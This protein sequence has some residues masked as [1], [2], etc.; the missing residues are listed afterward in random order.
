MYLPNDNDKILYKRG[1]LARLQLMKIHQ[2]TTSSLGNV[3]EWFDFG[4][5]IFLAPIIGKQFFSTTDET[6]STMAAFTVFAAGF[7]CRPI[8]GILFGH[9]GDRYGRAKPLRYSIIITTAVTF[10][11]GILPACTTIGIF[12]PLLFTLLRLIQGI[13]IGGEYGGIMIYLAETAP[14]KKRGFITSFAATGANMGFLLATLGTLLLQSMLPE[15]AMNNWGWRIPFIFIGCLGCLISYYRLKLMETPAYQQVKENDAI[16]KIP[17]FTALRCVPKKLLQILGLSGASNVFYYAFFGYMPDYLQ[18]YAGLSSKTAF[19][20]CS[21]TLAA[22]LVLVPLMSIWGDRYGRKKLLIIHAILI[23]LFA[24]PC[25][26]WLNAQNFGLII[27]ALSIAT[28]LGSLGQGLQLAA[29]VENCPVDIRYSGISLAY[30]VGAATFGG[31]CPLIMLT[32][33][34][35]FNPIAPAYYLIATAAVG[36]LSVA[37]LP[38]NLQQNFLSTTGSKLEAE[39][40]DL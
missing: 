29:T 17:L 16:K 28:L 4:L 37:T 33:I 38:D 11:I 23:M 13:S 15:A 26:Y 6:T 35:I 30:N 8:G 39:Q 40:T 27:F 14:S 24:L 10:L 22:M 21:L 20:L 5:F 12:A 9:I 19:T 1:L 32:L 7:I 36:L 34:Q 3:L 2:I 31:T 18:Q 25:F